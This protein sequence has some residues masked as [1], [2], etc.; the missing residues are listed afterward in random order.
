[1]SADYDESVIAE[2]YKLYLWTYTDIQ[3]LAALHLL[4]Q[5]ADK[6]W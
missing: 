2:Q 6:S 4:E 5:K 1:M 3:C